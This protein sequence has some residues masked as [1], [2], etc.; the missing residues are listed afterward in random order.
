MSKANLLGW[1]C[2][3]LLAINTVLIISLVTKKE[4]RP[5]HEGP[6]NLI[7][8]KLHFSNNQITQY[9]QYIQWHRHEIRTREKQIMD[10]KNELYQTLLQPDTLHKKDE[11]MKE[12]GILQQQIEEIH[13]KHFM[14]IKHLCSAEQQKDFA[15]LT[16]EIAYLFAPRRAPKN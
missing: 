11:L 10:I 14:D 15:N 5:M 2:V 1:I 7:I 16:E 6:R 3:G 13:Y 8:E 4:V 9:D 12:L